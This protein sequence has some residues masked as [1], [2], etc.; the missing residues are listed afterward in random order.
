MDNFI[1]YVGIESFPTNKKKSNYI[2][3][4]FENEFDF[5]CNFNTCEITKLYINLSTESIK[6]ISDKNLSFCTIKIDISIEYIDDSKS[7]MLLLRKLTFYKSFYIINTLGYLLKLHNI[8][9]N[10]KFF[11]ITK[12][13]Y[14]IYLD[15][16][17][18]EV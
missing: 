12:L 9:T 18:M 13:R 11:E 6:N 1:E 10:I 4:I 17:S 16:Y 15:I 2:N 5:E 3:Y 14:Y 7:G 8:T